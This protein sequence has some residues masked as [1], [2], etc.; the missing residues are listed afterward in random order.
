MREVKYLLTIVT[1]TYNRGHLLKKCYES[2]LAQTDKDFQWI[3]VDDGSAD[4]TRAVVASFETEEFEIIYVPKENGGKHT[5]LNASHP[6]IR[7]EYVLILDSDDYLTDTAVAQ[8]RE[9]WKAWAENEQVSMVTF[10]KGS[11]P[12]EP[13]CT[14]AV[15]DEPVDIL[16]GRRNVIRSMDCCEV[17]RAELFRKYPFPVFPGERF[18]SECA[19]WN[20]VA[21]THKCVYINH[22]VYICEYLEGG[23]TDSGRA[24]RI[25]NPR[26]GMFT[27]DLR[28]GRNN[29]LKQRIKYG[30]LYTCYGFFAGMKPGEILAGTAHKPVAALC[31]APGYALYRCWKKRYM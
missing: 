7:G 19:L 25:R 26:G 15:T 21:K 11:S 12:E 8:V 10:L 18:V 5:A 28:M 13:N 17:I 1:P 31:M 4:D 24:M 29:F 6:H 2:L 27:S 9:G 14:G 23:L 16:T 20:R 22:V 3:I 30:L